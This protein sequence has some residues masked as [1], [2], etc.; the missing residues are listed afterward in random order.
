MLFVIFCLIVGT[1][2]GYES[3]PKHGDTR[4]ATPMCNLNVR[5]S[6]FSRSQYTSSVDYS[7]DT[8]SNGGGG[9]G[10]AQIYI[11]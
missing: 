6:K 4:L 5:F 7:L 10:K 2:F 9:G 1:C 8:P 11:L 3:V